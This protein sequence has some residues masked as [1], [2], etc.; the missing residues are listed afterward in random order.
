MA[1]SLLD[2]NNILIL[3]IWVVEVML[4]GYIYS[5]INAFF[6]I[7]IYNTY[8]KIFSLSKSGSSMRIVIIMISSSLELSNKI[9][10]NNKRDNK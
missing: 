1:C 10:K 9:L 6:E 4:L 5:Y 8:L 3:K 2:M 7:A